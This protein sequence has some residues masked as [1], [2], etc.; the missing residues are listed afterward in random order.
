MLPTACLAGAPAVSTA[1]PALKA[2][3]PSDNDITPGDDATQATEAVPQVVTQ[4]FSKIVSDTYDWY[5]KNDDDCAK[6]VDDCGL[7]KSALYG[8]VYRLDAPAKNRAYVFKLE[9][10]FGVTL[11]Y[12]AI[13]N[14]NTNQVT[15]KPV[16]IYGKWLDGFY[17]D[18][19]S[20]LKLRKPFISFTTVDGKAA[21]VAE[22][23]AHNGDVYNAVIYRYFVIEPDL[24]LTQVLALESADLVDTKYRGS[25][26]AMF[27]RKL[28]LNGDSTAEIDDYFQKDLDDKSPQLV[29]KVSIRSPAPGKPYKVVSEKVID[30][31]FK[32]L[33]VTFDDDR[34]YGIDSDNAFLAEGD[35]LFY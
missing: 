34:E 35:T 4:K 19:D 31:A 25:Y 27:V 26:G 22:N 11:Y 33:L 1:I 20:R 10:L 15:A 24:S 28:I 23:Y 13:Y 16:S 30:Q 32:D 8:R 29:G 3:V 21:L 7:K 14:P 6:S 9:G 12:F 5:L 18:N 2:I 17:G